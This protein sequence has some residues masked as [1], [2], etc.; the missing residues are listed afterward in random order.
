MSKWLVACA[1]AASVA[2]AAP[3]GA[4]Q[5]HDLGGR[6][7]DADTSRGVENL[8]VRLTPPRAVRAPIRVAATDKNGSFVFRQLAAGR[9]LVEVSQGPNLLYR[10]EVDTATTSQ[11]DVPL[12]RR[13]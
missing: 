12:R 1:L 4:Q 13:R 10:G 9:Y 5:A 6:V 3:L 2:A 11:M 8:E 7:F